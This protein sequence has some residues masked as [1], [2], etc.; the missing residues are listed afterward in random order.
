MTL[1]ALSLIK[2]VQDFYGESY[3]NMMNS[4]KKSQEIIILA[5]WTGKLDIVRILILPNVI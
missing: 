4:K 3:K 1:L 2:F 5:S